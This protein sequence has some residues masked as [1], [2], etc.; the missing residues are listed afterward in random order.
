M[1]GFLMTDWKNIRI[2]SISKIEKVVAEFNVWSIE[3]IP[4]GKFRVKIIE[5]TKGGYI[6]IPN[7]AVKNEVD[8]SPE[9]ISG[10]G[11]SIEEALAD[12]IKYFMETISTRTNLEE[13]DFEWASPE[14]F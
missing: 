2:D 9:W 11:I 4:Y 3:K 13:D 12:T 10:L 5:N 6:G 8:G 1:E 14:D 7:I